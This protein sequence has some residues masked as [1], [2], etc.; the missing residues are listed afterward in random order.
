MVVA[1]PLP[2][3][4]AQHAA[5]PVDEPLVGVHEPRAAERPA[6]HGELVGPPAVVLV[7]QRDQLGLRRN[8]PQGALEV[9]IEAEPLLGARHDEARVAADLREQPGMGLGARRVVAD[10]ADPVLVGLR[11]ERLELDPQQRRVGLVRRH[12]DRDQARRRRPAEPRSGAARGDRIRPSGARAPPRRDT[13]PPRPGGPRPPPARQ[14]RSGAPHA[15][16]GAGPRRPRS[17]APRCRRVS[18]RRTPRS[19][20][21]PGATT[22]AGSRG[23]LGHGRGNLSSARD[24]AGSS[25]TRVPR[26]RPARSSRRRRSR[27]RRPG[28][29]RAL[30]QAYLDLLKLTLCDLAGTSTHLGRRDAGRHGD[31]ARAA[32]RGAGGCAPPGSTGRCKG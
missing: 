29:S 18:P 16:P 28:R 25:D 20:C 15:S 12:A 4:L 5:V 30:R 27:A 23:S 6:E 3:R 2:Q 26:R 21:P 32:R 11:A 22:A 13:A 14:P 9:A 17:R 1:P 10:D 24:A 8:Q 7:A 19:P 31:V